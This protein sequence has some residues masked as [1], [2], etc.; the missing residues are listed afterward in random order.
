MS[1]LRQLQTHTNDLA[2]AAKTLA[3]HCR[4]TGVG[5]TLH[6]TVPVDAPCEVHRAR[7]NVLA[8]VARL[9]TLLAQPVDLIQQLSSQVCRFFPEDPE[10]C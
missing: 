9:Q 8:I 4:D 5:S 3:E 7:R 10:P 2:V 6:L 1:S